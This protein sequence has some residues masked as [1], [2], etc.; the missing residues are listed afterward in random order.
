MNVG[1]LRLPDILPRRRRVVRIA[2]I[3]FVGVAAATALAIRLTLGLRYV[4]WVGI[5]AFGLPIVGFVLCL[6]DLAKGSVKL[7]RASWMLWAGGPLLAFAAQVFGKNTSLS[8]ALVNLAL[9]V[10]PAI[11]F[12]ASLADRESEWA[13]GKLEWTCVSLWALAMVWW[14][15]TRDAD[16]AILLSIVSEGLA[17]ASTIKKSYVDPSQESPDTYFASGAGAALGLITVEHFAFHEYAFQLWVA[18]ECAVITLFVVTTYRP[19]WRRRARA[20]IP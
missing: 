6:H 10:G 18:A 16:R 1:R 15:F 19:R 3:A 14:L 13:M 4:Q 5:V 17:A 11:I 8:I 7:S 12:L 20:T 9:G 2:G